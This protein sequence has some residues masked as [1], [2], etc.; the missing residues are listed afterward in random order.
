MKFLFNTTEAS[1]EKLC[2]RS[3]QIAFSAWKQ[4][5]TKICRIQFYLF[6]KAKVQIFLIGNLVVGTTLILYFNSTSI[7]YILSF[8]R[9]RSIHS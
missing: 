2:L 7:N 8:L 9:L 1:L 3:S 4:K 6:L 5:Q